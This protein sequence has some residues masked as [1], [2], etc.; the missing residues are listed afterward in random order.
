MIIKILPKIAAIF[1]ERKPQYNILYLLCIFCSV[2]VVNHY[3]TNEKIKKILYY[4]IQI[5]YSQYLFQ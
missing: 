4:N 5:V 3:Y 2:F 1:P